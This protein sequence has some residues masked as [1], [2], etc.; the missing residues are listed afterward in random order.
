MLNSQ[1]LLRSTGQ[2]IQE[3]N[4]LYT[5]N[6]NYINVQRLIMMY[7]DSFLTHNLAISS[8][9]NHA[10]ILYILRTGTVMREYIPGNRKHFYKQENILNPASRPVKGAPPNERLGSVGRV[11]SLRGREARVA[12]KLKL[13]LRRRARLRFPC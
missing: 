13:G 2:K 5:K 10:K 12:R 8:Q 4:S 11:E 6:D 3:K 1:E 7:H 9:N